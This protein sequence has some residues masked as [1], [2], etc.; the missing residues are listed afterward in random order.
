[1]NAILCILI[2]SVHIATEI[3]FGSESGLDT[4]MLFIAASFVCMSVD[5]LK[6]E[7]KKLNK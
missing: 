6:N 7:V 5:S 3:A 4:G 1:M 2:G